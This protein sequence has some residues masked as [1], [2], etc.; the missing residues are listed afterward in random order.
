MLTAAGIFAEMP[1]LIQKLPE[2]ESL[3]SIAL[4]VGQLSNL[5]LMVTVV[6]RSLCSKIVI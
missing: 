2:G 3:P 5:V 1:L 4:I 6:L